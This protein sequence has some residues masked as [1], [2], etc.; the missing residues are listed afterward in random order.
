MTTASHATHLESLNCNYLEL[1]PSLWMN[2][3]REVFVKKQRITCDSYNNSS[4]NRGVPVQ[5][6]GGRHLLV[7]ISS[8]L[9]THLTDCMANCTNRAGWTDKQIAGGP[10][11]GGHHGSIPVHPSSVILMES[12]FAGHS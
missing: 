4:L 3:D 11:H 7:T 10:V 2:E 9:V 8:N 5:P 12:L 1:A 6:A